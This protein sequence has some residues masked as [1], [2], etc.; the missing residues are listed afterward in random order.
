MTIQTVQHVN[1]VR[2]CQNSIVVDSSDKK[3]MSPKMGKKAQ[4]GVEEVKR[5]LEAKGYEIL[6]SGDASDGLDFLV[7]V[8]WFSSFLC[9][10]IGSL[11]YPILMI[12]LYFTGCWPL[13]MILAVEWY[14]IRVVLKDYTESNQFRNGYLATFVRGRFAN[15]PKYIP[16]TISHYIGPQGH[17]KSI[18]VDP[19]IY[20]EDIPTLFAVH[21]HGIFSI[22]WSYCSSSLSSYDNPLQNVRFIFD[23]VLYSTPLFFVWSNMFRKHGGVRAKCAKKFMKDQEDV[24]IVIG[25]FQEA[26]IHTST[27]ERLWLNERKGFIALAMRH[28][29]DI[30]PVFSFGERKTYWN[31]QYGLQFRLWLNSWKIPGVIPLGR[32][33]FLPLLPRDDSFVHIVIGAPMTL[34][35][36]EQASRE[37][38]N[39]YHELYITKLKAF[40]EDLAPDLDPKAGPLE[41]W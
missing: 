17:D 33:P 21:P 39:F 34:P 9:A 29:Y 13:G 27:H 36:K 24:A 41:I 7:G 4:P 15:I 23:D 25:G 12:T 3:D 28:G 30:R 11:L 19:S 37:E 40:Y 14:L 32:W 16:A 5:V 1:A 20:K 31:C 2:D 38:V 22:G 35:H 26:T 6:Q 8:V 10:W 18:V